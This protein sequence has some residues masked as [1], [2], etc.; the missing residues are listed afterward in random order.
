MKLVCKCH[1]LSGSCTLKTCWQKVPSFREIGERLKN[2]FDGSAKVISG[3]DGK[4]IIPA[5]KTI[6]QP[7]RE[8]LIY[9]EDSQDFCKHNKKTGSLGTHG[10]LCNVSS[11]NVDSCD[12]LC[13]SRGYNTKIVKVKEYCRCKF[14][15][16]CE[17]TCE[18][19]TMRKLI[20][21]C[22]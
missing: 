5:L 11:M 21:T 10:R 9:F 13:C 14:Q 17:V 7:D 3:N 1:G 19:C 4:S 12:I 22:R 6:K 15:W 16:C 2:R 8:D 20:T 18:I